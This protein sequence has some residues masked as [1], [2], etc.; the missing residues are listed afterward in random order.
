MRALVLIFGSLVITAIALGNG[1]VALLGGLWLIIC[2]YAS[3]QFSQHDRAWLR[4]PRSAQMPHDPR[5]QLL[6][7]ECECMYVPSELIDLGAQGRLANP[8]E[9]PR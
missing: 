8:N 1:G 7:A 3:R 2:L 4:D 6:E 9:D 5:L